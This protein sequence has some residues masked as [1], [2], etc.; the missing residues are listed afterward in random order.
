MR[1]GGMGCLPFNGQY[2]TRRTLSKG[3][4]MNTSIFYHKNSALLNFY[5]ATRL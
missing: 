5:S 4:V 2:E 3:L 1:L